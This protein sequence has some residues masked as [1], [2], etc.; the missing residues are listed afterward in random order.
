MK[1]VKELTHRVIVLNKGAIIAEG[2]YS[3]VSQNKEV[4]A[5]YLGE[6]E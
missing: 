1:V 6:E 3:E 2:P 5:A 4:I